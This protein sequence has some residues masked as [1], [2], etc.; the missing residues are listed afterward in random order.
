MSEMV[1]RIAIHLFK[2]DACIGEDWQF[3]APKREIYRKKARGVIQIMYRPT[4]E[5]IQEAS[6]NEEVLGCRIGEL[7]AHEVWEVMIKKA[8]E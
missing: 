7:V 4:P 6:D 3:S 8:A 2:M 1:E 5:M